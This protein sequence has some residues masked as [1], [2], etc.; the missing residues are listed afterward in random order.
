MEKIT[1]KGR[2]LKRRPDFLKRNLINALAD[3]YY[4]RLPKGVLKIIGPLVE[5]TYSVV[6]RIYTIVSDIYPPFSLFKEKGNHDSPNLTLFIA[7][8]GDVYPF[9]LDRMYSAEPKA[10]RQGRKLMWRIPFID[11]SQVNAVMIEA[12]RCFSRFLSHR[13]FVA[14]PEWVLFTMDISMP[15]EEIFERW[16]KNEEEYKAKYKVKS[17]SGWVCKVLSEYVERDKAGT[18]PESGILATSS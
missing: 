1:Q 8:K 9:L 10:T 2:R 12:D 6:H 11:R 3:I 16:K 18:L 13:G 15:M 4:E 14:I 17:F 5:P 7:G